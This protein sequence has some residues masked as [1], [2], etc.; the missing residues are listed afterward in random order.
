MIYPNDIFKVADFGEAKNLKAKSQECTLRGSE[1]Y[2]SPILYNCL[3]NRK[4]DVLHNAYKSD[5]FSFGL[6]LLYSMTLSIQV[7]NDIREVNSMIIINQIVKRAIR[8][9]YSNKMQ[10]LVL[11]ML[12]IEEKKRFSFKEIK[13]YIQQNFNLE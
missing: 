10:N 6:C 13:N 3:K 7:L 12:E 2:M 8:R 5:V 1:L 4:K 9:N 11:G